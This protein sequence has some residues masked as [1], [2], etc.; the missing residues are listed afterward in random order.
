MNSVIKTPWLKPV[1]VKSIENYS[2]KV[3]WEDGT[4]NIIYIG[5]L[6]KKREAFW[7]L[8]NPRYFKQV[9]ID[10]IGGIYWPQGE[11]ISPEIIKHYRI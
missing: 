7:R 6:I 10:P 5:E 8:R 11:D 4:D 3:I 9:Q 2:L 1:S